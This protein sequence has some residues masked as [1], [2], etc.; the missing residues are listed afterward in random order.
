MPTPKHLL[1]G[2]QAGSLL[3]L[4]LLSLSWCSTGPRTSNSM[5]AFRYF[6]LAV[7]GYVAVLVAHFVWRVFLRPGKTSAACCLPP[8]FQLP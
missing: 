8:A 6:G 4:P 5:D 7:A 2:K 1:T 3:S